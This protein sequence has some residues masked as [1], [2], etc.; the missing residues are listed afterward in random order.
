MTAGA[1]IAFAFAH[2][3]GDFERRIEVRTGDE[4]EA[5]AWLPGDVARRLY[6]HLQAPAQPKPT[7][8]N[9]DE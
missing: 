8:G 1:V 3:G 6:D 4:L 7:K 5:L 9:D 2:G